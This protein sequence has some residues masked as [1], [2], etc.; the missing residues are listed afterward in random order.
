MTYYN[1][2]NNNTNILLLYIK[3]LLPYDHHLV[4]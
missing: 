3:I 4:Y 2:N 1:N